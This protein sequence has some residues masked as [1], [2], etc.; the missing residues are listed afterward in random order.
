MRAIRCK[1]WEMYCLAVLLVCGSAVGGAPEADP[2]V[3]ELERVVE[4]TWGGGKAVKQRASCTLKPPEGWPVWWSRDAR[5]HLRVVGM[6]AGRVEAVRTI[7]SNPAVF[8]PVMERMLIRS[9]EDYQL[10]KAHLLLG[11]LVGVVRSPGAIRVVSEGLLELDSSLDDVRR[12]LHDSSDPCD[13]TSR[14]CFLRGD[15]KPSW[16]CDGGSGFLPGEK[17]RWRN[18]VWRKF[19]GLESDIFEVLAEFRWRSTRVRAMALGILSQTV[20]IPPPGKLPKEADLVYWMLENQGI[21]GGRV[22]A[23]LHYLAVTY[24]GEEGVRVAVEDA[25][26]DPNS[27]LTVLG[28]KWRVSRALLT[29]GQ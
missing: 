18:R 27:A 1:R 14:V 6:D 10:W 13:W 8:V 22:N 23:A 4:A 15:G 25:C 21:E 11:L 28:S 17:A 2:E 16:G 24:A 26:R 9:L 3:N 29:L 12:E 5:G 7:A 20:E 19:L